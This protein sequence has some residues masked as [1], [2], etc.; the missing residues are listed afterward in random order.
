MAIHGHK[1]LVMKRLELVEGEA[2]IRL[3]D[4][5]RCACRRRQFDRRAAQWF[6]R[7]VVELSRPAGVF[8]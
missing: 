1:K 6:A 3:G 2:A 7:G 5:G 8:G 4:R